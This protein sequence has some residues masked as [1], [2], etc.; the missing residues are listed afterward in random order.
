MDICSEEM[1]GNFEVAEGHKVACWLHETK[2]VVGG[3]GWGV[4]KNRRSV[5]SSKL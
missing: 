2:G 1:P 4:G 3:S 5:P